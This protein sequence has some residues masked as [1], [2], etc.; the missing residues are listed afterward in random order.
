MLNPEQGQASSITEKKQ[1]CFDKSAAY[2]WKEHIS[3]FEKKCI[4][5]LTKRSMR[6]FNY[7]PE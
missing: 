1:Q 5:L 3:G 7:K 2:R 6:R 4:T